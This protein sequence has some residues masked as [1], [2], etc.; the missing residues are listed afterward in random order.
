MSKDNQI[1]FRVEPE[2]KLDF[3]LALVYRSARTKKK[4]TA[5]AVMTEMINQFVAEETKLRREAEEGRP[6]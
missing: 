5:V 4:A 6:A 2:L 3:E 1:S